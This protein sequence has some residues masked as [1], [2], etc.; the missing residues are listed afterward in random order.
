MAAAVVTTV[1]INPIDVIRVRL[2]SQPM[3]AGGHGS[4]YNGSLDCLRKVAAKEGV[5]ALW[6]GVSAAFL[7]IGP[8]TVLTFTFIGA[9]RRAEKRWRLQAR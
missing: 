7:R 9:M 4:L 2:Y 5:L 8:H 3:L 1:S 6:K